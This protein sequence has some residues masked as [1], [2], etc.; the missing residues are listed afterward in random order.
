[1][2]M[3]LKDVL[4]H[5]YSQ[6]LQVYGTMYLR[7]NYLPPTLPPTS[8]HTRM[9]GANNYCLQKYKIKHF[10]TNDENV[11]YNANSHC[12]KPCFYKVC[13][14]MYFKFVWCIHNLKCVD[15]WALKVSVGSEAI[16]EALAGSG[17]SG[18]SRG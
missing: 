16:I 4:R 6:N 11:L 3:W 8:M 14:I 15:F 10:V 17:P 1:M 9:S 12:L 7:C 13:T 5:T 18:R 2:Q